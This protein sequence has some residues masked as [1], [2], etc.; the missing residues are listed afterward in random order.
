MLRALVGLVLL[1]AAS[2]A[3]AQNLPPAFP[4]EEVLIIVWS[5]GDRCSV[6]DR[7]TNCSRVSSLLSG[8]MQV[9]RE[10]SIVVAT[11]GNDDDVHIRAA[12]VMSDIRAAGYRNVRPALPAR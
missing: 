1:A 7:K 10:R 3:A 5:G 9:G 8:L 12:Q 2:S 6:L 4:Q 11:Q